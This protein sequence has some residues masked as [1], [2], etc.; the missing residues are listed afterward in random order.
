LHRLA[1]RAR[2]GPGE[3]EGL[4]LLVVG[5]AGEAA[6]R[7]HRIDPQADVLRLV[8]VPADQ[9]VPDEGLALELTLELRP[10][11]AGATDRLDAFGALLPR[12]LAKASALDD[13][14]PHPGVLKERVVSIRRTLG[15]LV[16][17]V[18]GGVVGG[19]L[20]EGCLVEGGVHQRRW[21]GIRGADALHHHEA[22][23]L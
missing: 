17:L 10:G 12:R 15:L 7:G 13:R 2:A 19:G 4:R 23:L 5:P 14:V 6:V 16:L 3:G 21:R 1:V 9:R 8:L 11:P 20:V 22:L 18:E